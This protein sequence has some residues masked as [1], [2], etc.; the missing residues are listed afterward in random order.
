MR[1][2]LLVQSITL[3]PAPLWIPLPTLPELPLPFVLLPGDDAAVAER[4][5]VAFIRLRGAILYGRASVGV[6]AATRLPEGT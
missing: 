6:E 2:L 3:T 5:A 4:E 1:L